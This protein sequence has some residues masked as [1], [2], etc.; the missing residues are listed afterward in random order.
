MVKR[1]SSNIFIVVAFDVGAYRLFR[2][3]VVLDD[4]THIAAGMIGSDQAGNR[5]FAGDKS[6]KALNR[7]LHHPG[8]I[9]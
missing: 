1:K 8:E 6:G 3:S 5:V 7:A 9:G 4:D 2:G